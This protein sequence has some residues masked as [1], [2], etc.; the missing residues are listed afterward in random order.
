MQKVLAVTLFISSQILWA[1]HPGARRPLEYATNDSERRMTQQSFENWATKPEAERQA[2]QRREAE[3]K[4]HEFYTKAER[5]VNLWR[6]LTT[7][8]HDQKTFNMKLAKQVSK[9]FHDLEKSDGWPA[10][11][12]K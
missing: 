9:A 4:F 8:M 11:R 6:K 3:Q 5:F 2:A 7:E 12:T 1:Q 10:E